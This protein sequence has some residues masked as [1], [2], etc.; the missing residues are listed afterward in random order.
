VFEGDA[1]AVEAMVEW[2]RTG[3]PLSRVD[4]VKVVEEPFEGKFSGFEIR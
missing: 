4:D 1:S 3:S 2:C